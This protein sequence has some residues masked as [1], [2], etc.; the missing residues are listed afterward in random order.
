MEQ[1]RVAGGQRRVRSELKDWGGR[2]VGVKG[3]DFMLVG[4]RLRP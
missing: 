4:E 1:S 3:W 2:P